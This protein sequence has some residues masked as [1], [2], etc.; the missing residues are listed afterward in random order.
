[1]EEHKGALP[2]P[3]SSVASPDSRPWVLVVNVNRLLERREVSLGMETADRVEVLSGLKE[4]ELVVMGSRAQLKPG[5]EVTPK[6]VV[7]AVAGSS[8][9]QGGER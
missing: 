8:A 3:I 6:V 1:M 4:N 5:Q 7:M 9:T 2:V